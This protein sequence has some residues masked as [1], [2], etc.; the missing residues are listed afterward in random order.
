MSLTRIILAVAVL[1]TMGGCV[2]D[3]YP[4]YYRSGYPAGTSYA[5]PAY[6]SA[7]SY[8]SQPPANYPP[9]PPGYCYAL[10]PR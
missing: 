2:Y 3:P 6:P 5:A 10:L 8:C 1:A 4:G 7:P 9:A